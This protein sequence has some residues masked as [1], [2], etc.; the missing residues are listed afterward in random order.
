MAFL[1]YNGRT[2]CLYQVVGMH[3]RVRYQSSSALVDDEMFNAGTG[4]SH[5]EVWMVNLKG[6]DH[7]A[8]LVGDQDDS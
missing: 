5:Y 6:G 4:K 1:S 7:D 8:W 3:G 2:A